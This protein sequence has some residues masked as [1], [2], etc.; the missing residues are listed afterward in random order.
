MN[1]IERNKGEKEGMSIIP[2]A[3]N[4]TSETNLM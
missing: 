2:R 1:F 4:K 3:G